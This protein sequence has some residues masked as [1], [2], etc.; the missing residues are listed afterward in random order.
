MT[1]F[2]PYPRY[3]DSH[4]LR[5]GEIPEHWRTAKLKELGQFA[6]SGIDKKEQEGEARVRMVNY[7]DVYGNKTREITKDRELMSTTCPA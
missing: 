6:S 7:T 4:I 5:F 1:R 3:K 2:K